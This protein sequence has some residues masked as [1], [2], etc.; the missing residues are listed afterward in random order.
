M[1][2]LEGKYTDCKIFN[3]EVEQTA[4]GQVYQ[5]LNH[6]AFEDKRTRFM[7]DIHAGAGAVIG[8]TVEMGDKIIPNVI[9]VDIGCGM[10]S[11]KL[12]KVEIDYPALDT[13]IRNNIPHGHNVNSKIDRI[14]KPFTD[15]LRD[16]CNDINIPVDR[17]YKSLCS[18]G[19][20]NHF[21]EIGKDEEESLWLTVHSG[22]RNFGLQ[23]AKYHQKVAEDLHNAKRKYS[24]EEVLQDTLPE[25]R[26]E[27]KKEFYEDAEKI[28]KGM[29]YLEGSYA[30]KYFEHM[31]IAQKF[32]GINRY[33]MLERILDFLDIESIQ[34]IES[35]HNYINFEDGIIR[36]GAISAHKGELVIIPWNMRDGLI[37]GEGKG[38]PDWNYSAPHGAGR[39]MSRS[40]AK[41]NVSME[42]FTASMSGI[43]SSSV[44]ESTLDE[45]P[46]AYKDPETI[47]M[48][49]EDTV[50]ILHRVKPVYNFKA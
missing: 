44:K 4:I 37:I 13:F 3:D 22:S 36:K 10:L 45:S 34:E 15:E 48:Y 29:E 43:Y 21:I 50:E 46:M 23:I 8:T 12:G 7:P 5:F 17:V 49:L 30:H 39:V 20:G 25:N 11:Y 26:E 40:K 14:A 31:K 38:N 27:V 1:I 18:L 32:A 9:G 42:E 28:P 24:L 19:G 47:E 6:P 35:V 2:G 41:A 33:R 16:V